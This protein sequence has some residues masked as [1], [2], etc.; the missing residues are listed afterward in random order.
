MWIPDSLP[1]LLRSLRKERNL[2]QTAVARLC[3]LRQQAISQL[4]NGQTRGSIGTLMS[5]CNGLDL[6]YSDV[7]RRLEWSDEG[8]GRPDRSL[9]REIENAF[10]NP[11]V[12]SYQAARS[13]AERVQTLRAR[14]NRPLRNYEPVIDA[15]S[16]AL[17]L[18]A[19]LSELATDSADEAL[20]TVGLCAL[21][22][23]G[24]MLAPAR[25]GSGLID[26]RDSKK[27]YV[28]NRLMRALVFATGDWIL[29]FFLQVPIPPCRVD[30]LV[31]VRAFSFTTWQVVEVDGAGHDPRG[32]RDRSELLRLPVLRLGVDALDEPLTLVATLD[33]L[34]E[35]HRVTMQPL[36]RKLQEPDP[37]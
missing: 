22:A 9:A 37:T 36:S 32:D 14:E 5:L 27:G 2:S 15:R 20:F 8:P 33:A 10:Q 7:I 35:H 19:H 30:F 18:C 21:G 6:S 11:R 12:Y 34:K 4:E 13:F 31:A 24:A 17:R 28:G 29:V 25:L 23:E 16:D 26:I 1:H 3:G